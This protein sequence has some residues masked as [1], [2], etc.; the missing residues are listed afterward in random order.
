MQADIPPASGLNQGNAGVCYVRLFVTSID[1]NGSLHK[2]LFVFFQCGNL[3]EFIFPS[4]YNSVKKIRRP[5]DGETFEF[6]RPS[7]S[8]DK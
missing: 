7:S 5:S 2:I 3:N 8:V 4:I 6:N 1:G